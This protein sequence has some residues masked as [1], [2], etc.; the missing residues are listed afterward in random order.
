[1]DVE[2]VYINTTLDRIL[3]TVQG[4]FI[5]NPSPFRPDQAILQ[6]LSLTLYNNEFEFNG[7]FLANV[8]FAICYRPSVCLS[9][10]VC[11]SVSNVRAPYSGGSNFRQYF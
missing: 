8:T 6:L 5:E 4:A 9:S 10:V 11:L 7:Q 1:M 2:S 3:V